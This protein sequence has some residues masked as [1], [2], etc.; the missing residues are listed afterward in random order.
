MNLQSLWTRACGRL[1]RMGGPEVK[2]RKKR[3]RIAPTRHRRIEWLERREVMTASF[4]S[5]VDIGGSG[6]DAVFDVAVDFAGNSYATGYFSGTVDF[7]L[8][9]SLADN[10]DIL[11]SRGTHD[12]FVAKYAPDDSLIWVRRMGGDY[13][14]EVSVTDAARD[15]TVDSVGNVYVAG[16]FHET[17][18]FGGTTLTAVGG[19][20][21][22]ATKLS[23]NGDF[24]W[25]KR[26]GTTENDQSDGA[27]V[28]GQGNFYVVSRQGDGDYDILKYSS[29]G[30]EVWTRSL[31]GT[32]WVPADLAVSSSGS[33]YVAG[34][35]DGTVDFDPSAKTKNV[36]AGLMTAAFVLNLDAAGKFKWVTPFVGKTVNGSNGYA[37]AASVAVDNSGGVVVGGLYRNTVDFNPS[38][39]TTTLNP[40]GGAYIARLNGTGGLSWAKTLTNA[41]SGGY[42]S[43]TAL[44]VDASGSIYVAGGF[45]GSI[46][47][48]PGTPSLIH[49]TNGDTDVFVV[50][51]TASG[52]F[53]WGETFG[54]VRSESALGIDVASNGD[55]YVAISY[56][57]Q[58]D[59]DPSPLDSYLVGSPGAARNGLRLRLLQS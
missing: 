21:S 3:P 1:L 49:S 36:S 22:F 28:D 33:V 9:H 57:D 15:I 30:S 48:D 44:A 8:S 17:A 24:L 50:K 56:A 14:Y 58:V 13:L 59:F 53:V 55:V 38:S 43:T 25:A 34:T 42:T 2:P 37:F 10:A 4:G 11:A 26:W 51:L 5:A 41:G 32:Y 23:G 54:G 40:V 27:D 35:F 47:L 19:K 6:S 39:S 31:I 12:A 18:D 46:D 52:N 45:A 7:D 29:S 20:D 16:E